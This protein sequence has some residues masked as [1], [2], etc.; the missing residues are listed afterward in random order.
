MYYGG[1]NLKFLIPHFHVPKSSKRKCQKFS[2]FLGSIKR[3][4]EDHCNKTS[5]K[6]KQNYLETRIRCE[7]FETGDQCW[8]PPVSAC[9]IFDNSNFWENCLQAGKWKRWLP[10]RKVPTESFI[11][12]ATKHWK[13]RIWT[14]TW[15][16]FWAFAARNQIVSPRFAKCMHQEVSTNY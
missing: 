1:K 6:K 14:S 16:L 11:T 9:W 8:F 12:V 2:S 4:K 3:S 13:N 15:V 10:G 5:R 7:F